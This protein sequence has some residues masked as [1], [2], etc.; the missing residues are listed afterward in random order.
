MP[1]KIPYEVIGETR[2]GKN[3]LCALAA[4]DAVTVSRASTRDFS[5]DDFLDALAAFDYLR[6]RAKRLGI[7]DKHLRRH[8]KH[9]DDLLTPGLLDQ[10]KSRAGITTVFDLLRLGK[11]RLHVKFHDF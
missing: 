5:L 3:I 2:S 4:D 6:L 8:W 1:T 7:G 11:S 10:A 9:I